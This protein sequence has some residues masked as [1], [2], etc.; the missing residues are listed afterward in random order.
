MEE[1]IAWIACDSSLPDSDISVLIRMPEGS[2]DRVWIGYHDG[3]G[4]V[5]AEGFRVGHVTHWAD[6]PQGPEDHHGA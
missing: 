3:E 4:W 1:L 6:L 5:S 2:D